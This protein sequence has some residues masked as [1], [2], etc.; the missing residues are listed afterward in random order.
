MPLAVGVPA[1]GSY[2]LNAAELLNLGTVPTYLRDRQTGAVIDLARQASYQFSVS[3]ASA[4]ITGRFELV[5]SPQ[6]P[7]ATATAALAQQVALYPNPATGSASVELPAQLGRQA[8]TATLVDAVGRE[9]RTLTLP[10]QGAVAHTLDLRELPNG[11]YLLHL[12]TSAGTLV[13]KL[14]VN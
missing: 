4:L 5:F 11:V 12:H 1:V 10:A 14:T 3:D 2:V 13:K 7:L 6:A 8:V 9:V